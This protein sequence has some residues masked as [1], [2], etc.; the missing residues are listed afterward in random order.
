MNTMHMS[1]GHRKVYSYKRASLYLVYLFGIETPWKH[2]FPAGSPQGSQAAL[3]R[4]LLLAEGT[5]PVSKPKC[6]HSLLINKPIHLCIGTVSAICF[7]NQGRY[8]GVAVDQ[9]QPGQTDD[10]VAQCWCEKSRKCI[11]SWVTQREDAL[12]TFHHLC[13][14]FTCLPFAHICNKKNN[15]IVWSCELRPEKE[16]QKAKQ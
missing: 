14:D 12:Q 8:S 7:T 9:R 13:Q 5:S 15:Y 1:N 10:N 3:C 2:P 4:T 11:V 16:Q 6:K